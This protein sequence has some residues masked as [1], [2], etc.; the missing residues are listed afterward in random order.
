MVLCKCWNWTGFCIENRTI[1][2][3]SMI[4]CHKLSSYLRT[5]LCLVYFRMHILVFFFVCTT[6]WKDVPKNALFSRKCTFDAWAICFIQNNAI[7]WRLVSKIE[8]KDSLNFR[9]CMLYS[10]YT[11]GHDVFCCTF[12][13][14]GV[15]LL[16][17]MKEKS[18]CFIRMRAINLHK[19]KMP[20]STLVRVVPDLARYH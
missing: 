1:F 15:S 2:A 9:F 5:W 17:K 6:K 16:E 11:A 12:I 18:A 8:K 13:C 3:M 14:S 19:T 7:W 20:V 10:L 4:M